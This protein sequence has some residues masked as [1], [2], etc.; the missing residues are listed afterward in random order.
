MDDTDHK[1]FEE[2]PIEKQSMF[3]VGIGAS[4]GGLEALRALVRKLPSD[5]N[6]TYI[7]AQ[8]LSPHHR[9]MFPEIIGRETDFEVL[10]VS[11]SV[12]PKPNKIY[13]TPQNKDIEIVGDQLKLMSP[14]QEAASPKP[15]VDRFFR[16][17]AREKGNA[18][19]AIVLS[20]TGS[21]GSR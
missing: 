17:L 20:G 19:V 3:W 6:A 16:S 5:L 2:K 13:I 12:R 11:D 10:S 7:V 8:H 15:S 9:S 1:D 14:S 18:A 4:A 21:D